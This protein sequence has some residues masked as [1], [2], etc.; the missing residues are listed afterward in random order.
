MK[1]KNI[2]ITGAS[3]GI[4]AA[5]AKR[6]ANSKNHLI[7]LAR[8]TQKLQE[9]STN[10]EEKNATVEFHSINITALEKLQILIRDIDSKTPIDLIIC[11]AGI[12]S[13]I[14]ENGEAESWD[15]ICNIIDTNLYGV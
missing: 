1:R 14:G 11:N 5:L 2:L 10:C 15:A 6:Y 13:S 3:A 7:L 4:G 9:V 12:T 8:N